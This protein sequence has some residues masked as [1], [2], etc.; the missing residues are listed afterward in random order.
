MTRALRP[1]CAPGSLT[2]AEA[3][4][5]SGTKGLC[6]HVGPGAGH[7]RL[8]GG[9]FQAEPPRPGKRAASMLPTP[10]SSRPCPLHCLPEGP[11]A[12]S[13]ASVRIWG[14]QE[15]QSV[16]LGDRPHR[17][18]VVSGPGADVRS[19]LARR[20]EPLRKGLLPE[21]LA[22]QQPSLSRQRKN[23]PWTNAGRVPTAFSELTAGSCQAGGGPAGAQRSPWGPG[24]ACTDAAQHLP[25]TP[26][27]PSASDGCAGLLVTACRS[28]EARGQTSGVFS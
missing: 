15:S 17:P 22:S 5:A 25:V 8:S 3:A 21:C 28:H 13:G 12:R 10:S 2:D 11:R 9:R 26:C 24:P 23:Q 7:G 27:L 6:D 4:S 16:W 18:P 19:P 1:G 20:P 14:K